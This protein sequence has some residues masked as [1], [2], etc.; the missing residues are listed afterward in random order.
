MKNTP[1]QQAIAI[2]IDLAEK[3]EINPWDVQVIEVIDRFLTEL[4]VEVPESN[5]GYTEISLSRSGQAFL[6]ASMLILLKA[7][8]LAKLGELDEDEEEIISESIIEPD[9][10]NGAHLPSRLELHLRRR[11]GA[12]PVRKR[13]VTLQ[14]LIE[15][16]EEIATQIEDKP[17]AKKK[18]RLQ[19]RRETAKMI[20]QLAH[21]ENLTEVASFLDKFLDG[22]LPIVLP[23]KS[24]L[25]LEELI[26]LL[27]EHFSTQKIQPMGLEA[28][29]FDRVGVFWA[30]LLLSSQSK[31]ELSQQEFYQEIRIRSIS[32]TI[33]K[34]A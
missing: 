27:S 5:P 31:V 14:E 28:E 17:G 15:Q 12:P 7:N 2:L 22:Q 1:A 26:K 32:E 19:S 8:T 30:L 24:D 20:T 29:A 21:Q 13:R 34:I 3:G 25:E 9:E 16:I 23:E 11:A 33:N 10:E 6:W 4:V 18:I